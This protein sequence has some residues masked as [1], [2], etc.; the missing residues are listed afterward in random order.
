[1]GGEWVVNTTPPATLPPGTHCTGGSVSSMDGLDGSEKSRPPPR[2][3]PRT[4]QPVASRYTDWAIMAYRISWYRSNRKGEPQQTGWTS[5]KTG[6][7]PLLSG[8]DPLSSDI[9]FTSWSRY[10]IRQ[11]SSA[12]LV[13][14]RICK[15]GLFLVTPCKQFRPLSDLLRHKSLRYLELEWL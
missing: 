10:P 11:T 7:F 1:M 2:F 15:L 9:Q 8:V 13:E 4:V 14:R 12:C 5:W 6:R 3:D